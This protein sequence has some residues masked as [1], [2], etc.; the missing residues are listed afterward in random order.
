MLPT[1]LAARIQPYHC[2]LPQISLAMRGSETLKLNPKQETI[3]NT[4]NVANMIGV[5]R[6]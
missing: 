2:S 6:T 3:V 5:R 1:L 4:M